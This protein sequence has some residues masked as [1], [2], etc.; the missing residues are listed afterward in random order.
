MTTRTGHT[1]PRG[2]PCWVLKA[3]RSIHIPDGPLSVGVGGF[4]LC[5]RRAECDANNGANFT[6]PVES[7]N[8]L[9]KRDIG[10]CMIR[11]EVRSPHGDSHLGHVFDDVPKHT[12][13]ARYCIN[14]ASHALFLSM[15]SRAPVMTATGRYL[16]SRKD[17][18]H[19]RS[20]GKRCFSR[21]CLT[22][23]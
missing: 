17:W 19:S 6:K 10:F 11:T 23:M 22:G 21:A 4:L 20:N 9:E 12:V 13:G 1:P 5:F 15:N 2:R 8:V 18:R 7:S 3:N 16:A 14:S